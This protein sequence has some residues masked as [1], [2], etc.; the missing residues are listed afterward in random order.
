MKLTMTR[1][2]TPLAALAFAFSAQASLPAKE[3]FEDAALGALDTTS[4]TRTWDFVA[5]PDGAKDASAVTAYG[6]GEADLNANRPD[7]FQSKDNN[8]YLK[9]STEDGTL[10]RNV[11]SSGEAQNVGSGLYLDTTVQFTVTDK[12]DRPPISADDKFILWLEANTENNTT[13]IC[14]Y[15]GQYGLKDNII[16]LIEPKVYTLSGDIN[17]IEPGSWHRLTIKAVSDM[18]LKLN[19][20]SSY[21]MDTIPAFQ[22]YIDGAL[23][24]AN[25]DTLFGGDN[26]SDLLGECEES[27]VSSAINNGALPLIPALTTGG[28]LTKVGFSGEGK[29][30][31]VVIT[32]QMPGVFPHDTVTF[33]W[34]SDKVAS[35]EPRI[36]EASLG[37]FTTSPAT[38][39][40][41]VG[42]VVS[43]A[44]ED[45]TPATGFDNDYFEFGNTSEGSLNVAE[46]KKSLEYAFGA[47]ADL[48]AEIQ[49]DIA[50]T[51]MYDVTVDWSSMSQNSVSISSIQIGDTTISGDGLYDSTYSGKFAPGAQFTVTVT[52][53]EGV[54]LQTA[55]AV[56][57][58]LTLDGNTI[59]VPTTIQDDVYLTVTLTAIEPAAKLFEVNGVQYTLEEFTAALGA[60]GS[61]IT[62]S[63]ESP[64]KLLDALTLESTLTIAA[65]S[66]QWLDLAGKTITGA[67]GSAIVTV[68]GTLYIVDSAEDGA[69]IAG[70]GGSVATVSGALNLMAGDYTGAITIDQNS[71]GAIH[72][73]GGTY[74]ADVEG[75]TFELG[76]GLSYDESSVRYVYGAKTYTV[77][78]NANTGTGT[79]MA[80][81]E[82]TIASG[83]VQISDNGY[84]APQGM[85]FKGWNTLA[86]GEGTSYGAEAVAPSDLI[87]L[88][89]ENA[90][91][92][93]FAQWEEASS[94]LAPGE[95]DSTEY[96]SEEDAK[97]AAGSIVVAPTD[98][99][100][101]ALTDEGALDTY[102]GMFE[103]KTVEKNGKWVNEV[104]LT[105]TAEGELKA[106]AT[107]AVTDQV[108]EKLAAV[109]AEAQD[110]TV[111]A[112][113]GFYYSVKSG[114]ALDAMTEGVRKLATGGTIDLTL[115]KGGAAGFY[116]ILINI[117]AAD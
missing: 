59:T 25:G 41:P 94:P 30:D 80:D 113:P 8:N 18:G 21:A 11:D 109:A 57:G 28:Q 48:T 37:V 34:S 103:V 107:A 77:V 32:D 63:A 31:D 102:N 44:T 54:Q 2:L 68:A 58:G 10:F 39:I 85:K 67:A 106:N 43:L 6:E 81:T 72:I 95:Q 24:Q 36:G 117:K 29:L 9:L 86:S 97:Q 1:V 82:F 88:A 52:Y 20:S 22:V 45:I 35:I 83:D 33:T 87:A 13:N 101:A 100:K 60:D 73:A 42:A 12:S 16:G 38:I 40:V 49:L 92:T 84:V 104:A 26:A 90:T 55:Y 99:V 64:I 79:A 112:K 114:T 74:S 111:T 93:L 50:Y 66:T 19:T 108:V 110:I 56:D 75:A 23:M 91:I 62:S 116:K 5:A 69:M 51:I 53:D 46:D 47:E 89:D 98:E 7:A 70:D 65:G 76:Y 3:G 27:A 96:N 15:G 115:P 61:G 105:P 4:E 14:V 71:E 78:Y 17:N